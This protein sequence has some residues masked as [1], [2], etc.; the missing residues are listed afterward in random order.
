MIFEITCSSFLNHVGKN[1]INLINCQVFN[2]LKKT[3][4]KFVINVPEFKQYSPILA[5]NFEQ[6]R[7]KNSQFTR[8]HTASST[9][10]VTM[11]VM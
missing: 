6:N 2:N 10:G 1:Y 11:A 5:S 3:E 7:T 4:K 8:R 9:G